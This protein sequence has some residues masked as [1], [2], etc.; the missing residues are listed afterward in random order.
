MSRRTSAA[1]LY[2]LNKA[3]RAHHFHEKGIDETLAATSLTHVKQVKVDKKDFSKE[4]RAQKDIKDFVDNSVVLLDLS[5]VTLEPIVDRLLEPMIM[6]DDKES[7]SLEEVKSSIFADVARTRLQDKLQ[8]MVCKD[9]LY[10]WEQTWICVP[11]TVP[12][13]TK[14]HVGIARL[15]QNVNLG[16]HAEEIRFFILVLCPSDVKITK[17]A[18]ETARTFGTIFSDL[19][20]RHN[21]MISTSITEF[22]AHLLVTSNEFASHQARPDITMIAEMA[23]KEEKND[24]DEIKWYQVGRGLKMDFLRRIPYYLDDFKDGLI[25]PVGT[26]QKTIATTLFLYFSVI[27]PAVALGVLNSNNTNGDISV[28]QVIVGQTFGAIIFSLLAG[29]PL[30]VVMTTAPL[31]LFIK[32]IYSIAQ[33]FGIDFLAFYAAIGLWNSF[34]LIIYS[35]F[36]MSVL[37]KFSSRSTEEIFSNFITI[38]F[39]KDSTTNIVK[40]FKKHYWNDKCFSDP[41]N[42]Q[43]NNGTSFDY[44]K[45]EDFEEVDCNPGESFLSLLLML[46]TMWL[47]LTLFNFKQTPFLSR[48]KREILSDYALPVAVIVFSLIG[49]VLFYPTKVQTFPFETT[50]D[51]FKLVNFGSLSVGAIFGAMILGFSLSLLF[52]MDQ[53]ISAAMVDSPDNKLVKG[54]S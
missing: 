32:I 16:S 31:A 19:S 36:N 14:R 21:L 33:K 15:R 8:G 23:L 45:S 17:T 41:E 53:N 52:F 3:E 43:F 51:V 10:V 44:L 46:G 37:M 34:F 4:I 27:L 49:S 25:G 20:L 39:I 30:V 1:S 2:K 29:Q 11:V 48:R 7:V 6:G 13:L 47:G 54:S 22:K 18:L 35:L 26:I 12:T 5:E 9:D 40:T 50:G 28:Y 42:V 38:A 24:D